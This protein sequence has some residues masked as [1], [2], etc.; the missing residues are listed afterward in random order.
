M[1]RRIVCRSCGKPGHAGCGMHVEQVLAGVA[2]SDRC[3]CSAKE[4]TGGG[5]LGRLFGRR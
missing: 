2:K 1:C 3:S 4:R 5:W